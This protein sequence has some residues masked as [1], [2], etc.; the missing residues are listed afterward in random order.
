FYFCEKVNHYFLGFY[1]VLPVGGAFYCV[2]V[3]LKLTNLVS[4]IQKKRPF[5]T[6]GQLRQLGFG[7][8]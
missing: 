5:E 1:Q 4:G 6:L 2:I 8:K 7:R 3:P